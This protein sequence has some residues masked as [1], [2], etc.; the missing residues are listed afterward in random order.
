VSCHRSL[1]GRERADLLERLIEE[2]LEQTPDD[3][4]FA[5]LLEIERSFADA[6]LFGNIV[7]AGA[8]ESQPRKDRKGGV[9][10]LMAALLADI[11]PWGHIYST[12]LPVAT[13]LPR[14]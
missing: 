13:R 10:D 1:T 12:C 11:L 2:D 9:H 5:L 7:H 14:R 8:L 4:V 3:G 6:S